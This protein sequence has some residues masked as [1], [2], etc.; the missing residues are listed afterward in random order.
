MV[1]LI[2]SPAF[3]GK[4]KVHARFRDARLFARLRSMVPGTSFQV[5]TL[6]VAIFAIAA[7]SAPPAPK[8]QEPSKGAAAEDSK[9]EPADRKMP[10][11]YANGV[12]ADTKNSHDEIGQSVPEGEI[13]LGSEFRD[14]AWYS[15]SLFPGAT[16]KMDSRSERD[17]NDMFSSQLLFELPPGMKPSGCADFLTEAVKDAVP[18]VTRKEEEDRI[19]L[20]GAAPHYKITFVCGAGKEGKMSAFVGYRWTSRPPKK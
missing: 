20:T 1:F 19:T 15:R 8:G 17:A 6:C 3:E 18:S 2:S 16:L 13:D 9:Q 10:T 12:G 4:N 7:C 5:S 11:Y 14:P